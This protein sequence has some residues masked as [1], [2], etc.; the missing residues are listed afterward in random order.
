MGAR[1][2]RRPYLALFGLVLGLAL[3]PLAP[4]IGVCVAAGALLHA[5]APARR[6]RHRH[7]W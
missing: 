7:R 3:L 1:P 5:V 4:L 2:L 6:R